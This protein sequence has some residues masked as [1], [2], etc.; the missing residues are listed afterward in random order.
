MTDRY[1]K[2]DRV[3]DYKRNILHA[4]EEIQNEV[5]LLSLCAMTAAPSAGHA[6]LANDPALS[7]SVPVSG[8]D[9]WCETCQDW[10]GANSAHAMSQD[11]A[12]GRVT[13]ATDVP[14]D[15]AESSI[16]G[17]G[18]EISAAASPSRAPSVDDA[19]TERCR[20]SWGGATHAH[21]CGSEKGHPSPHI[22]GKPTGIGRMCCDD[23]LW[24]DRA[25]GDDELPPLVGHDVPADAPRHFI[26]VGR[27]GL[28]ACSCGAKA[29]IAG[30]FNMGAAPDSAPPDAEL[31]DALRDLMRHY[32]APCVDCW[33]AL[34][35]AGELLGIVAS[36]EASHV[37]RRI[38]KASGHK[39][40]H[41]NPESVDG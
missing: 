15:E 27:S 35:R 11:V 31:R 7:V 26:H 29:V 10:Y 20:F 23:T 39:K 16:P 5:E 34:K 25:E 21:E 28:V 3:A 4:L 14:P 13:E 6:D 1:P 12:R 18:A 38:Y 36:T 9:V 2:A 24:G 19:G 30:S 8:G 37:A 17:G 22:C 40:S 33:P 32:H 41:R